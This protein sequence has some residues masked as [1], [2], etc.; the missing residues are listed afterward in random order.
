MNTNENLK[1][2]E[3][4]PIALFWSL[5]SQWKA[6]LVFSIIIA[7][8]ISSVNY[9]KNYETYKE[10]VAQAQAEKSNSLSKSIPE[11]IQSILSSLSEDDQTAVNNALLQTQWM[12]ERTSYLTDSIVMNMDPYNIT[13]L[14]IDYAVKETNNPSDIYLLTKEYSTLFEDVSCLESLRDVISPNANLQYI[15]ELVQYA[16]PTGSMSDSITINSSPDSRAFNISIIV[17]DN[18]DVESITDVVVD[19][20]QNKHDILSKEVVSH[21]ISLINS[22]LHSEVCNE[23]VKKKNDTIASLNDLQVIQRG[24]ITSLTES[25]LNAFTSINQLLSASGQSSSSSSLP[26]KPSFFVPR[27]FLLYLIAGFALYALLSALYYIKSS[28]IG[29]AACLASF[30]GLR[31]LGEIHLVDNNTNKGNFLFSSPF[32]KRIKTHKSF[33]FKLSSNTSII[34][35]S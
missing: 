27:K 2:Y 10:S 21:E 30:S 17:P 29:S 3:I 11:Q 8:L 20:V 34:G 22:S 13:I 15:Y 32:I 7:L 14:S 12:K 35:K 19:A 28:Q 25:Q 23:I 26:E 31:L 16:N 1:K 4:D 6:A 18:S 9:H 5:L 33:I 24:F